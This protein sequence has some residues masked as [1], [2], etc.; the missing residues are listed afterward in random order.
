MRLTGLAP[1]KVNLFLHVG[2][3]EPDGYHPLCSLVAFA[4]VGDRVSVEPADRLTLE[5]TGPFASALSE[6]GGGERGDNLILKA[7]RALGDA[8]GLGE[9]GLRVILDKRLPIAAGL[10]G[11][12]ADAGTSLKLANQMLKLGMDEASLEAVSRVVGADGP[13]CLRG[14]TAWAEGYG[15]KLSDADLM[16][17]LHAVLVNPGLP[18][19]TGAVYR[20]YDEAP[21]IADRPDPPSDWSIPAVIDWLGRCRNNLELPAMGLTPGIRA[22]MQGV[23]EIENVRLTRMSGSGAT[24]FGLFD[25]ERDARAAAETLAHRQAGWWVETCILGGVAADRAD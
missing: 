1:A 13:M 19:P 25:N 15:E 4:D 9:P 12:S 11:G 24:V 21:R 18:S 14:R 5:V 16:P 20:A 7:L 23:A 17:P 2:P 3:I 10:G 8:A 6:Q 22:A